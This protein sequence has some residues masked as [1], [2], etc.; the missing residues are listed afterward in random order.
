[1][2]EHLEQASTL[3]SLSVQKLDR[4]DQDLVSETSAEA[5]RNGLPKRWWYQ[6]RADVMA[7]VLIDF[8]LHIFLRSSLFPRRLLKLGACMCTT[9]PR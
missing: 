1:M 8:I 3:Y 2:F 4:I 5:I 7:K 6:K 9:R